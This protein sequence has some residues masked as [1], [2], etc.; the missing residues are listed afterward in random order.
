MSS[1]SA[2]LE[3]LERNPDSGII[4]PA[5]MLAPI[6]H[7]GP[8]TGYPFHHHKVDLFGG[9]KYEAL[10]LLTKFLIVIRSIDSHVGHGMK[11]NGP[12]RMTVSAAASPS[13]TSRY[14]PSLAPPPH[15]SDLLAQ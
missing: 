6:V 14:I 4:H 7:S 1:S 10:Y 13:P 15:H 9:S 3:E 12:P 8:V 11:Q 5:K 2:T